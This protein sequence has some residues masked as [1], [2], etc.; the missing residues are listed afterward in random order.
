MPELSTEDAAKLAALEAMLRDGKRVRFT[1][2]AQ[3]DWPQPDLTIYYAHTQIDEVPGFKDLPLAPVEARLITS[4]GSPFAD[5]PQTAAISDDSVEHT[6]SDLDGEMSRLCW[7]YGAGVH[8]RIWNYYPDVN[9]LLSVFTGL[10]RSPKEAN[11]ITLKLG[12]TQGFRSAKLLLPRRLPLPGCM[13]I[14]GA[15]LDSQEE[16]DAHQG[17]PYNAHLGGGIGVPGFTDCPRDSVVSCSARLVTKKYFPG[18]KT[19]VEALVKK[20]GVV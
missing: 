3:I 14:F 5:I 10:L 20:A 2:L 11:G 17:C 13:F 8:M 18:Y 4:S 15:L 6:Y 12:A 7:L 9:L 1:E 19:V 16:I